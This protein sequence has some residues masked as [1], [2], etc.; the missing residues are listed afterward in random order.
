MNRILYCLIGGCVAGVIALAFFQKRDI[1]SSTDVVATFVFLSV[2]GAATCILLYSRWGRRL[3]SWIQQKAVEE[4]EQVHR[5][6]RAKGRV[7]TPPVG[8]LP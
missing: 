7:R 5:N 1:G 2:L 6:A 4:D 3:N 8:P